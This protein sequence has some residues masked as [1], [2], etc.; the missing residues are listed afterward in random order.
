LEE[1]PSLIAAVNRCAQAAVSPPHHAPY[2]LVKDISI[3]AAKQGY[4]VEPKTGHKIE[5]DGFT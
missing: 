2:E 3:K 5:S 4:K 1:I